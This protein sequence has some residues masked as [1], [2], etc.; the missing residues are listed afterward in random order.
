[1]PEKKKPDRVT[2]EVIWSDEDAEEVELVDAATM[3]ARLLMVESSEK[4]ESTLFPPL[5][6]FAGTRL[7]IPQVVGIIVDTIRTTHYSEEKNLRNFMAKKVP[8][9][10][11]AMINDSA[12]RER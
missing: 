3:R 11:D 7:L 5:L 12:G 9:F 2:R 4:W 10:I 6:H 1:M 8:L